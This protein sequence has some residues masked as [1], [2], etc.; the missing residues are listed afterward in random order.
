MAEPKIHF[1][2]TLNPEPLAVFQPGEG[3]ITLRSDLKNGLVRLLQ[4]C[5]TEARAHPDADVIMRLEK[6]VEEQVELLQREHLVATELASQ[7]N[8]TEM[9]LEDVRAERDRMAQ[10][11]KAALKAAQFYLR[12]GHK[13]A[14]RRPGREG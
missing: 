2:E 13:A 11:L 1:R 14:R 12:P 4:D 6:R 9:E 3:E 8:K 5:I 7:L 10:E